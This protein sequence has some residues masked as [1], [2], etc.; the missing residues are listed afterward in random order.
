MIE[1]INY[2]VKFTVNRIVII[3]SVNFA[4]FKILHF[5]E[6]NLTEEGMN[7]RKY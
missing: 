2:K 1:N 3:L 5:D 4:S 6:D 7:Y